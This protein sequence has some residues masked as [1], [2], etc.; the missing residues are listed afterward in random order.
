MARFKLQSFIIFSIEKLGACLVFN[1][2]V[3]R[4]PNDRLACNYVCWI[5]SLSAC[6]NSRKSSP[7]LFFSSSLCSPVCSG[8][9]LTIVLQPW[10]S[11]CE[12]MNGLKLKRSIGVN[13]SYTF[14]AIII[15][16]KESFVD[17]VVGSF[18][19]L[20]FGFF[21]SPRGDFVFR[22]ISTRFHS[23][24]VLALSPERSIPTNGLNASSWKDT[25]AMG[26]E[27]SWKKRAKKKQHRLCCKAIIS[28]I[29][30]W[31][32]ECICNIRRKKK[33]KIEQK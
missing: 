2:M 13:Y 28:Y 15:E 1:W 10:P 9:Y 8:V 5:S 25:Q 23:Q 29:K 30:T 3:K 17:R 22:F 27:K 7:R 14:C 31:Y 20:F 32:G 16:Q 33:D 4:E 11:I 26:H 21:R 24:C 6:K 18:L 12:C 19:F